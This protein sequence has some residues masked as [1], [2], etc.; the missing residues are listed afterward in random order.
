MKTKIITAIFAL[1][2]L[3][4]TVLYSQPTRDAKRPT[5]TRDAKDRKMSN[6]EYVALVRA[7]QQ[8]LKNAVRAGRL[9][10]QQAREQLKRFM[11]ELRKKMG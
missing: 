7:K 8:E 4:S 1:G 2:I 9:T 6:K 5:P 10:E 11:M 3:F